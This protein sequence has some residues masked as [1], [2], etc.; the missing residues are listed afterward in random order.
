[1]SKRSSEN[2]ARNAQARA[3][4]ADLAARLMAE[5]GIRDYALAKRKAARQLALPESQGLPSNGEV[6]LALVDRQRLFASADQDMHLARLRA[7]A[8]EV[9]HIFE[10]FAP[11][12]TGGVASGVVSDHSEIELD[13]LADASKDFEQ[14]LI[15]T[16]IDFKILDRKGQMAYRIYAQPADV[17]VRLLSRDT[18]H[19]SAAHRPQLNMRQLSQLIAKAST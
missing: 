10:R 15:N 19:A 9:M 1:M 17:L 2:T 16:G 4:I 14:F 7:E 11:I 5:H 13:V 12:L 3:R 8:L 18:R 6:D